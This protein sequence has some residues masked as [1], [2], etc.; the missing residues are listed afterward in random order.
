MEIEGISNYLPSPNVG[1]KLYI[2]EKCTG[3][4]VLG[5]AAGEVSSWNPDKS[6]DFP[7]NLPDVSPSPRHLPRL[8]SLQRD[9]TNGIAEQ[10]NEL[11]HIERHYQI[12][13]SRL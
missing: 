13:K 2:N 10:A 12:C 9:V 6:R 1:L 5:I 8:L 3:I 4:I 7:D 11:V